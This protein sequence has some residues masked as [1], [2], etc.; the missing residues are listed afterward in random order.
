MQ[1]YTCFIIFYI[2]L[3]V[4]AGFGCT[5]NNK[6]QPAAER[7]IGDEIFKKEVE[8]TVPQNTRENVFEETT[9]TVVPENVGESIIKKLETQ[10][11]VPVRA[12]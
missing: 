10:D 11:R 2:L 6:A 5:A 3:N 1:N 8:A 4:I 12:R 9:D 7:N